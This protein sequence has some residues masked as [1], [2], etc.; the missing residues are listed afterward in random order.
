MESS[1]HGS[2]PD[3]TQRPLHPKLHA[4]LYLVLG[5]FRGQSCW[6]VV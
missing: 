5:A 1:L 2:L 4:C 3:P 6:T